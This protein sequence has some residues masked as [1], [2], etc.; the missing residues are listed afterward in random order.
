V[1]V[2]NSTTVEA[3]ADSFLR[4]IDRVRRQYAGWRGG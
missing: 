2:V 3:A 1:S 4:I